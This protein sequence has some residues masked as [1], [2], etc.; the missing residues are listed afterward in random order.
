MNL[1]KVE[2]AQPS[3]TSRELAGYATSYTNG[4]PRS[5][6]LTDPITP[7]NSHRVSQH[8]GLQLYAQANQQDVQRKL[9]LC[10]QVR[11]RGKLHYRR[12]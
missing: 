1:I 9:M 2:R 7:R 4:T 12:L 3:A 10:H 8:Q 11:P 5:D 6:R